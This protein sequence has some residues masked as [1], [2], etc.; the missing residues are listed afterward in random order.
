LDDQ[1]FK[2]L[3][4]RI[5]EANSVISKL[6]PAIRAEA[7]SLLKPYMTGHSG[8]VS[9]AFDEKEKDKVATADENAEAFFSKHDA[10]TP[11]ENALLVAAYLYSLD[12]SEPFS[13]DEIR[14]IAKDAGITIPERV[15]MTLA[16]AKREGKA[17]FRR[18]GKGNFKATVHGETFFKTSYNVT[19]G[20]KQR[21]SDVQS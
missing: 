10:K 12:G 21:P 3:V 5:Q 15:D 4:K 2:E 9:H 20:R 11:A 1:A 18:V 19:K 13:I 6:D 16:N 8:R 7:F 17:L 14:E